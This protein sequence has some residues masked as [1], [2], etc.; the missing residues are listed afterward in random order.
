MNFMKKKKEIWQK[1]LDMRF[2]NIRQG[3]IKYSLQ[4]FVEEFF[5]QQN[6]YMSFNTSYTI[7]LTQCQLK[8]VF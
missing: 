1:R 8:T 4:R 7:R 2:Q 5:D 3:Y 6:C